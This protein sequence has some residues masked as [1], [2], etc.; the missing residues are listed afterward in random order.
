MN[1]SALIK[2][3]NEASGCESRARDLRQQAAEIGARRRADTRTL[4]EVLSD[5]KRY[6][7]E[8][9][10]AIERA[11]ALL[12]DDLLRLA[13]LDLEGQ[14]R[15]LTAEADAKRAALAAFFGGPDESKAP[16]EETGS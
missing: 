16:A 1:L 5:L 13:E 4:G 9:R 12:R 10:A 7:E 6:R 11:E 8:R 3:Q 2:L 14:A 15:R